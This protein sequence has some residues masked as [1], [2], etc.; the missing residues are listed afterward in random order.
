MQDTVLFSMTCQVVY[1]TGQWLLGFV[2]EM[3]SR[4]R[5]KC[6]RKALIEISVGET[7]AKV[8]EHDF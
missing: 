8:S 1:V 2:G 5:E 7:G 6:H 4:K 3:V